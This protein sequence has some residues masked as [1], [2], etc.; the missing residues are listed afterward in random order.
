MRIDIISAVP[1]LI[2]SFFSHS[3]VKQ[4]I[5]KKVVELFLHDL[6]DYGKG[7][8]RQIDDYQYGGGAGMVL[9]IEPVDKL[10]SKLK[11]ERN[12]N[13]IIFMTPDAKV[14]EQETVNELSLKQNLIILAGHYKGIDQSSVIGRNSC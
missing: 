5:D 13:E 4:A 7:K 11:S 8:Y 12:Y 9:M 14:L 1:L 10:I 2:E 6:H 3:I